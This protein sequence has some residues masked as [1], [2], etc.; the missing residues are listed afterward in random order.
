MIN[1]NVPVEMLNIIKHR[2]R[3]TNAA[4]GWNSKLNS[5]IGK[6]QPNVFLQVQKSKQKEELVSWQLKSKNPESLVRNEERLM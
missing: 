6:Q 4:E 1:Q 2:H 3:T 5:F